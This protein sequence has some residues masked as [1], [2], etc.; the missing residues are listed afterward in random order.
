MINSRQTKIALAVAL[1]VVLAGCSAFSDDLDRERLAEDAEYDWNQSADATYDV[2]PDEYRAVVRI[3][4]TEEI[5]L[6]GPGRLGGEEPL[7][8]RAI[9]FR[10]ENGTV[11]GADAF[12]AEETSDELVLT[13]PADT[14]MFAYS[15]ESGSR[16]VFIPV[17]GTG[18]H[19]V[20]LPPGM[21]ASFPVFGDV[22]P[23]GYE[24]TIE[25]DRVHVTW[26]DAPDRPIHVQYYLE[27][28]LY[29]FGGIVAVLSVL[30][31][32]GVVYFRMKIRRL[33]ERR[34]EAGLDLER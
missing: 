33:E 7:S 18:S 34:E 22:D 16:S 14:G 6:W 19:E 4:D 17:V 1:L 15:V 10:Y 29:I 12:E 32:I 2:Q 30:G 31:A 13:P 9:K 25:D 11:V 20:V 27:R 23:S 24:K 21:R 5:R 3:E 26:E 8:V 28:D